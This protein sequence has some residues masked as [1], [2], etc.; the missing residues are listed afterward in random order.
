M[1][2][3]DMVKIKVK[4][5]ILL[6]TWNH[7]LCYWTFSPKCI[8]T[9]DIRGVRYFS[10]TL[11]MFNIVKEYDDMYIEVRKYL[12]WEVRMTVDAKKIIPNN[13]VCHWKMMG[14]KN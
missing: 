14:G 10:M 12:D 6:L 4:V 7:T 5:I 1:A 11:Y 8:L 3:K 9:E 13:W 2:L